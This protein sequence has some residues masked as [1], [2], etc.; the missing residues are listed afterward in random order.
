VTASELTYNG[1]PL[2]S[3]VAE[4]TASYISQL[5]QH[6]GELTVR[7]TMEFSARVQGGRRGE[8]REAGQVGG[9]VVGKEGGGRACRA[10]SVVSVGLDA[11]KEGGSVSAAAT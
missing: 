10:G 8:C 2:D 9:A 11:G 4:R 1:Q 7:Q 5:D 6:Y 3:F